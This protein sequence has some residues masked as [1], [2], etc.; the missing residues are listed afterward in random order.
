MCLSLFMHLINKKEF[1]YIDT[2]WHDVQITMELNLISS[3]TREI[4]RASRADKKYK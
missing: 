2:G 1:T 3:I 4:T